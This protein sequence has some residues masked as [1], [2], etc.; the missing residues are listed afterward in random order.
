LGG[1]DNSHNA[2]FLTFHRIE[3]FRTRSLTI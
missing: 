3:N 2:N 1:A